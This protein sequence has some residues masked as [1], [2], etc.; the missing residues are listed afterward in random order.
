MIHAN[1]Q[2]PPQDITL[3]LLFVLLCLLVCIRT[4]LTYEL[5]NEK[6][7]I[8]SVSTVLEP[9]YLENHWPWLIG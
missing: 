4:D 5:L 6:T 3:L 9:Y 1:N 8:L 2:T 7:L